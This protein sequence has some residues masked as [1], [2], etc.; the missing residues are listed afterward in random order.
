[1]FQQ[2]LSVPRPKGLLCTL[3]LAIAYAIAAPMAQ[4]A[5]HDGN[6]TTISKRQS[7][8]LKIQ[9]TRSS[10]E[11]TSTERDKRLSRECQGRPNSGMCA[12]YAYRQR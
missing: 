1:M 5:K 6:K 11:E 2:S 9:N 10:S 3:L 12:G 8:R 4:A 7:S